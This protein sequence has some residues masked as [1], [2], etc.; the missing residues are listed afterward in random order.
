MTEFSAEDIELYVEGEKVGS[1]EGLDVSLDD[2][3][4]DEPDDED[5]PR[6]EEGY[7]LRIDN[8]DRIVGLSPG[9][10]LFPSPPWHPSHTVVGDPDADEASCRNIQNPGEE[11]IELYLS[12]TR[13]G[14]IRIDDEYRRGPASLSLWR[15]VVDQ[16]SRVVESHD[17]RGKDAEAD[18]SADEDDSTE[19]RS[20][21]WIPSVDDRVVVVGKVRNTQGMSVLNPGR[22]G[23]VTDVRPDIGEANVQFEARGR[24]TTFTATVPLRKLAPQFA[25]TTV[26]EDEKLPHWS[27]LSD[28]EQAAWDVCH[29]GLLTGPVQET[30][31]EGFCLVDEEK[32]EALAELLPE[33]VRV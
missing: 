9:R 18:G 27:E 16:Y 15:I 22:R 1:I 28:I 21:R 12:V 24:D 20:K 26:H 19:A 5:L 10:I 13:N 6:W 11:D 31:P 33:E 17:L 3:M 7:D 25:W 23:I 30:I 29:R 2:G 14:H 4:M 32:I 8:E